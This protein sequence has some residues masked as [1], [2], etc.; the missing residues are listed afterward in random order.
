MVVVEQL[1]PDLLFFE[2]DLVLLFVVGDL[3]LLFVVG[4]LVLLFVVG[5]LVLLLLFPGQSSSS[6]APPALSLFEDLD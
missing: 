5:D 4:D 1:L 2:G 6:A 3:V